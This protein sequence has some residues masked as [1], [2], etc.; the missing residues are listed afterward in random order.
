MQWTWL[1][2]NELAW[3]WFDAQLHRSPYGS[4]GARN[5]AGRRTWANQGHQGG[6]CPGWLSTRSRCPDTNKPSG[7]RL[8]AAGRVDHSAIL[9]LRLQSRCFVTGLFE[10]VAADVSTFVRAGASMT[11]SGD[12]AVFKGGATLGEPGCSE[13]KTIC[14]C[15]CMARRAASSGVRK[16]RTNSLSPS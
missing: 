10:Q 4:A 6:I 3:F 1:R 11:M 2:P 15:E 12:D 16:I 14:V 9:E 5:G 7:G 13:T 8:P